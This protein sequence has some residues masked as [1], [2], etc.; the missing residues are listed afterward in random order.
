MGKIT[1]ELSSICANEGI[2]F[3]HLAGRVVVSSFL[4]KQVR[5]RLERLTWT[6][7]SG[8]KKTAFRDSMIIEL[9]ALGAAKNDN[10]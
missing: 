10:G 3:S 2:A 9:S 6:A 7:G 4:L 8:P 1:V 5:H